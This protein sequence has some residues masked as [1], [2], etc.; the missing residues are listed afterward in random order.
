MKIF[1]LIA[2]FTL[3]TVSCNSII[4]ITPNEDKGIKEV[5]NF[6]GGYCKYSIGASA[7]T[8]DGSKKY[9]ELELSKSEVLEKYADMPDV[10]AS[11]IAY[12]FYN[13]LKNES[14][15]YDEV[16]VVI[17]FK[18]DKYEAIYSMEK[19]ELIKSKMKV[20]N[21]VVDLIKTKKFNDLKPFLSD[22]SYTD[23]AKNN[24]ILNIQKLDPTFGNIKEFTPFGFR[25]ET[26]NGFDL[27]SILGAMIRDKENNQF[28]L[29][30]DLKPSE[31][32]V[33]Y[34]DYKF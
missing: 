32:K 19:L 16:H 29:K 9:F 12:I 8:Q 6:Y 23:S 13:N 11:N 4:N 21:Q 22:G 31:N 27:V 2:T 25:F 5:I 1:L 33:H 24:L 14:K 18:K 30:V 28:T 26:I 7:S 34:L 17:L 3:F 10:S 15:N 20:L